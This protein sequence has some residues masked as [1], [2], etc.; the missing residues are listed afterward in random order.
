MNL[1]FSRHSSKRTNRGLNFTLRGKVLLT[2]E[3]E[4]FYYAVL[5]NAKTDLKA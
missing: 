5:T 4:Y 2:A 1:L 3:L